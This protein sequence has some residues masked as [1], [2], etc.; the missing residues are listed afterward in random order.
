MYGRI[1]T[2]PRCNVKFAALWIEYAREF[3]CPNCDAILTVAGREWILRR[4]KACGMAL[5]ILFISF[6]AS[7]F[8]LVYS[9]HDEYL[10]IQR[11]FFVC[12]VLLPIFSGSVF[13]LTKVEKGIR[14]EVVRIRRSCKSCGYIISVGN[15]SFCPRCGA[16]VISDS[17][18]CSSLSDNT[19]TPGV[20]QP[21]PSTDI[22]DC[23]ICGQAVRR[24]DVSIRCPACGSTF[25]RAHML[26]Y[27][28]T[29]GRCPICGR[30]LNDELVN[31]SVGAG[32]SLAVGG[33]VNE[34]GCP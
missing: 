21:Y 8:I 20:C 27:L 22:V 5:L 28:H 15:P 17:Y 32:R 29:H 33:E 11:I 3:P 2:C 1:F 10:M 25:H 26:E 18:N 9:T 24:F 12:S 30:R 19:G 4:M 34:L 13:V 16:Q 6:L 23:L 14:L 31:P 7:C